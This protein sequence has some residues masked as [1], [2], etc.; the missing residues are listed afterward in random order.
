LEEG[1]EGVRVGLSNKGGQMLPALVFLFPPHFSVPGSVPLK[2]ECSLESAGELVK[3]QA[4]IHQVWD[5][6]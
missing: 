4:A 3:V 5:G 6:A 2:L 1:G